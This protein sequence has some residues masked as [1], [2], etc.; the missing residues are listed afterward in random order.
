[1]TRCF[2]TSV[3]SFLGI[4]VTSTICNIGNCNNV[5]VH[6]NGRIAIMQ[7]TDRLPRHTGVNDVI[8][9]SFSKLYANGSSQLRCRRESDT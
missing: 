1:M 5:A 3:R 4:G 8:A 7:E 9:R 2:V 6:P